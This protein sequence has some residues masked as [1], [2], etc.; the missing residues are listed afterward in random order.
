LKFSTINDLEESDILF[1]A[2]PNGLPMKKIT[3]LQQKAGKIIDLSGDFRLRQKEDYQKWYGED[4]PNPEYLS[5]FVYGMAELHREKIKKADLVAGTGCLATATITGLY[6]LF[7]NNLVESTVI[8]EAK[9]GSS[10]SGN[11]PSLASHHSERSHAVRSFKPTGHRHTAEVEQ[12]LNFRHK[13]TVH[14]SGTSIEL[15]R[16]ILATSHLFLKDGVDEKQIWNTYRQAYKDEP[17][18]RL[19]K[20]RTGVYRYPEPKILAGTN[21]CEVGFEVDPKSNRLV[22]MGAIDNLMKGGAGQAVQS[23]N[24]MSGFKETLGLEFPGLHPV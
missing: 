7:K 23:M 20:K 16:G 15:I 10:A 13:P 2:L 14:F 21:I 5:K 1:L 24:L 8:T 17:F 12:E 18:V 3:E 22:V 19:V 6:P 11:K 9:V 4:H